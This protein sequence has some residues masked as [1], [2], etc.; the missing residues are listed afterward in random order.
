MKESHSRFD[1]NSIF[2]SH[3]ERRATRDHASTQQWY[4]VLIVSIL[5]CHYPH[6]NPLVGM[7]DF[8]PF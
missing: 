2:Q 5:L 8:Q 1:T 4:I 3:D 6:F 7:L